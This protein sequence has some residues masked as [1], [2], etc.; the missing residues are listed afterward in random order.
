KLIENSWARGR[1]AVIR[2]ARME[3]QYRGPS[4]RRFDRLLCNLVRRDRQIFGHR[5]RVHRARHGACYDDFAPSSLHV[6]L[7]ARVCS[8]TKRASVATSL[9]TWRAGDA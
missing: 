1:A 9:A 6:R 8:W 4:T 2:V 7:S 3:V 5:R